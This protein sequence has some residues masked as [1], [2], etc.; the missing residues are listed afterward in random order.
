MAARH[1]AGSRLARAIGDDRKGRLSVLI[2][3]FAIAVAYVNPW[4]SLTLYFVVAG[5]W[6]V[7]DPWI[8]SRPSD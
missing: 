4:I 7:P 6:F 2:Y 3:A 5:I 1:G 8:E